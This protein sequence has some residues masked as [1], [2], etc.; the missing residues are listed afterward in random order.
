MSKCQHPSTKDSDEEDNSYLVYF[1]SYSLVYSK[2][3][4]MTMRK[5][6]HIP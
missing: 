2:H 4:S 1:S 5:Y 6:A 3:V